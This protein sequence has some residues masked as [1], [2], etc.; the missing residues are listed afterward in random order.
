[1]SS[2]ETIPNDTIYHMCQSQLWEEAKDNE[3]AYYPPTFV[4]D[5]YFTHAT[6]VPSRLIDTANHF[7]TCTIGD[8]IC[9]ELSTSALQ[10]V[11][12]VTRY[13]EAKPV[14]DT[15]SSTAFT[16]W[17]CPHIYGGIPS[18]VPGVVLNVYQ[19]GRDQSG[20]FLSIIGLTD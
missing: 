11:G 15:V 7:Y 19:M 10:K 16:A 14:G 6:A 18:N 17:Q 8:W 12:I 13:E 3:T 20:Q 5:G 2:T 9:L 1:M 4:K